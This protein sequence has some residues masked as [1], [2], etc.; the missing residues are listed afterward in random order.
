MLQRSFVESD[1]KTLWQT[2]IPKS[3]RKDFLT[4]AHGGMS[5]GHLVKKKTT[6]T[7]QARAYWPSWSSDFDLFLK[8]CP[9]CAK[10]YRGS[11][12]RNAAMQTPLIGQ[13]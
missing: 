1:G 6:S 8:Q 7:I 12:P 9:Q 4:E 13:P 2:V 10:Y 11:A 3:M 5:G